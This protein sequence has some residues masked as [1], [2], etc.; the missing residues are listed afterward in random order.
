MNMGYGGGYGAPQ[1]GMGFPQVDPPAQPGDSTNRI[2][3]FTG[4]TSGYSPDQLKQLAS[5]VGG[6]NSAIQRGNTPA[7]TLNRTMELR[8]DDPAMGGIGS[9]Y[10]GGMGYQPPMGYGMGSFN[11]MPQMGG[12]MGGGYGMP[13]GMGMPMNYGIGGYGPMMGYGMGGYSPMMSGMATMQSRRRAEG[14]AIRKNDGGGFGAQP[15]STPPPSNLGGFGRPQAPS[16][17]GAGGAGGVAGFWNAINPDNTVDPSLF[18]APPVY[19]GQR[20]LL[21]GGDFGQYTP[22]VGYT[23]SNLTRGALGGLG[24]LPSIFGKMKGDDGQ[25]YTGIL[26]GTDFGKGVRTVNRAAD[27]SSTGAEAGEELLKQVGLGPGATNAPTEDSYLMSRLKDIEGNDLKLNQQISI[28]PLQTFQMEGPSAVTPGRT[29]VGEFGAP[30][31][32][33]YMSPYQRSV[34]DTQKR[35]AQRQAAMQKAGRSAAAVRAGAFG[36]SR[37]AIQEG[38]ADEALQRQMGDIEATGMQRAYESAQGQF[39][40]D[41]AASLASQQAN[42]RAALEAQMANQQAGLTAG[43]A[44]LRSKLE[45]QNLGTMAGL[46]A[47]KANLG[48]QMGLTGMKTDLISRASQE[49]Q[50]QRQQ[51]F[52]NKLGA[53]G[54]VQ[55]GA[56]GMAGMGSSLMGIPGMAQQMELQRLAAMQQGGGYIDSLTR[57]AMDL[58]YQDFINQQNFPYQQMNFLTGI[59]HGVPIGYQTDQV[60]FQRPSAGGLSGL[61]ASGAGL[62]SNLYNK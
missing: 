29:E 40:R 1:M 26:P 38:M 31:A 23:V 47:A 49:R 17:G 28:D 34:I 30:T 58:D 45:T 4:N 44:N 51:D 24:D 8:P 6:G 16:H 3:G 7:P 21:M 59:M 43:Q 57:G 46:D 14:G 10:G 36:G 35:E 32:E 39:E 56:S 12:F 15:Q 50:A 11:P 37:Q 20:N 2:G 33:K 27:I 18:N 42:L 19:G 52:Q 54:Q 62:F 53:L 41:R 13:M 25:E 22:G 5:L 60:Q 55:A 9:L 48:A 61:I